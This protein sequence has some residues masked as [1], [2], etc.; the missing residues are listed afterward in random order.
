MVR[1][2]KLGWLIRSGHIFDFWIVA[3]TWTSGQPWALSIRSF[4]IQR[5]SEG[6]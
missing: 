4:L 6:Q 2:T 1:D 5:G 3:L